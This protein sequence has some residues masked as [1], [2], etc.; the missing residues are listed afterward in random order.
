MADAS[1]AEREPIE[2]LAEEFLQRRRSGQAPT[3][4]EYVE[5]YPELADEIRAVFPTLLLMERADPGTSE[6]D[7]DSVDSDG[8]RPDG[9][10]SQLG[11]FR[12]LR[13]VGRGGMGVVYEAEQVSLGRRVALKVLPAQALGNPRYLSRFER[14]AKAA[15]RLHHTNI[16]PVYGVGTDRGI[17]YY[18]MQF[19]HGQALNEVLGELKRLRKEKCLTPGLPVVAAD[20]GDVSVAEVARSLLTGPAAQPTV[21]QPREPASDSA[22]SRDRA[23][24]SSAGGSSTFTGPTSSTYAQRAYWQSVARVGL[25][26]AEALAY[27]HSEGILHRDIKPSNLLLDARGH[28]W[29]TDFG[30]AKTAD[31]EDLTTTGDIVGTVRYMA[32]ERFQG[33]NDV[34]SDVYALGV[35]LYE[36][37]ALTPAYAETDRHQLIKLVTTEEPTHLRRAAP[38][39]PRDLRTIVHK[40]IDR[41]PARRYAS[42]AA[43]AD[44]LQRFLED[45]PIQARPPGRAELFGRWCRRNPVV[46]SLLAAVLLVTLLGFAGIVIQW[47]EAVASSVLAETNAQLAYKQGEEIQK[48]NH[49]LVEAQGIVE[50]RNQA[51]RSSQDRLRRALYLSDVR[52]LPVAWEQESLGLMVDSLQRQVPRD[53]EPDLR[54]FEWHYWNRMCQPDSEVQ[55]EREKQSNYLRFADLITFSPDGTMVAGLPGSAP[56]LTLWDSR[57]GKIRLAT[58]QTVVAELGKYPVGPHIAFSPDG[59][60]MA[61]SSNARTTIKGRPLQYNLMVWD[62]ATGQEVWHT[63]EQNHVGYRESKYASI[64]K[65][66]PGTY[67]AFDADASRLAACVV[68]GNRTFIK[69]WDAGTGEPL[70]E[71]GSHDTSLGTFEGTIDFSPDGSRLLALV[72]SKGSTG[73]AVTRLAVWDAGS[74]EE[75][76]S[77]ASPAPNANPVS[78]SFSNDGTLAVVW[79]ASA[80]PA[81]GLA[82]TSAVWLHDA[83]T[84]RPRSL[85]AAHQGDGGYISFVKFSVAGK[86]LLTLSNLGAIKIWDTATQHVLRRLPNPLGKVRAIGFD[87]ENKVFTA[88]TDGVLKTWEIANRP[89]VLPLS[90]PS[91]LLPPILSA[92]GK[93]LVVGSRDQSVPEI[94]WPFAV[95]SART[96]GLLGSPLAREPVLAMSAYVAARA[97]KRPP[98][99]I[100]VRDADTGAPMLTVKSERGHYALSANGKRLASWEWDFERTVPN[101]VI[102]WE[103]DTGKRVATIALAD[104]PT[105]VQ[106][107][108]LSADGSRLAVYTDST[109]PRRGS[110]NVWDV[111]TSTVLLHQELEPAVDLAFSPD[112]NRIAFRQMPLGTNKPAFHVRDV[113][114]GK[115]VWT[116][117][118]YGPYAFSADGRRLAI[119]LNYRSEPK[120]T[121]VADAA[122]GEELLRLDAEDDRTSAVALNHDGQRLLTIGRAVRLWDVET[123]AELLTLDRAPDEKTKNQL[124]LTLTGRFQFSDDGRRLFAVRNTVTGLPSQLTEYQ[125]TMQVWDATPLADLRD[126]LAG[127]VQPANNR[128]R[129]RLIAVCKR[130]HRYVAAT[131]FYTDAFIAD[132]SLADDVGAG[133]RYDALCCSL[134]ATAGLGTD[135]DK[136]DDPQ[137]TRLRQQ[138]LAWARSDL[139]MWRKRVDSSLDRY[140]AGIRDPDVDR[141]LALAALKR[142]RTDPDLAGIRDPDAVAKLPEEQRQACEQLWAAVASVI[143]ADAHY[144]R[145]IELEKSQQ[146]TDAIAA[147]RQAIAL[148][149]ASGQFYLRLALA[150]E[151]NKDWNEA[152]AAYRKV[153]GLHPTA[154]NHARLGGALKAGNHLD[155]ARDMFRRAAELDARAVVQMY[156]SQGVTRGNANQL[157]EAI[158]LFRLAIDIDPDYADA[159]ANL[160]WVLQRKGKWNEGMAEGRK[161]IELNPRAGWYHNNLG[162][163]LEHQG[164]LE[165]ALAEYRRA[166]E[167]PSDGG[168]AITNLRNLEPLVARIPRLEAVAKGEARPDDS[169]ECIALAQLAKKMRRWLLAIRLYDE[170]YAA[171]PAVAIARGTTSRY[172]VSCYTV[173]AAI[174]QEDGAETLDD[175]ERA[176]LRKQALAWLR[177]DLNY[178]A[179]RAATGTSG[180]RISVEWE[181]NHWKEDPDLITIRDAAAVAKLPADEREVSRKLWADVEDLLK[182]PWTPQA[183]HPVGPV[184]R[185]E[186]YDL[187]QRKWANLY[188][189]KFAPDGKAFVAGGDTGPRGR[190]RLWE[191]ATGRMLQQFDPGHE[192]WFSG[193]LFLPDGTQFLTWYQ[194]ER[195]LYLWDMA[196]GKLLRKIAGH[197]N[198]PVSVAV[199]PDGKRLLA[200]GN[201]KIIYLYDFATGNE[202]A[203]LAG[204]TD[205]CSAVFS[206]DGKQVLSYSFDQTLRLWDTDSG[207]LLHTLAGHTAPCTGIFSPDGKQVLSYA[208]KVI[209]LWDAA[210][211]NVARVLQGPT[212]EV[213]GAAFLAGGAKVVAWGKDGIVRV[214][215]TGSGKLIHRFD[216]G[217]RAEGSPPQMA[218]T[219][220]GR[221]L[222]FTAARSAV[223]VIDLATGKQLARFDNA[224]QRHGF[225]VSPDS[226]YAGAG[227]FR[228]GV[229]VWRLPK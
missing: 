40:A 59:T 85:F 217:D 25:Q 139:D 102:V 111:A 158:A 199:T 27:A 32:P 67:L 171:N 45:R 107:F 136:L 55:L 15:A 151:A 7:N 39:M 220:D 31:T 156:V 182:K 160:A 22:G 223:I 198:D 108:A 52:L 208:D 4:G 125:V 89:L 190:L 100:E 116:R 19:I 37:A 127:K 129:L 44:D 187:E 73:T 18:A 16:V 159:H 112:G 207:K 105:F 203:R 172:S 229:Y 194:R 179:Q 98:S 61:V 123:G 65:F 141:Y 145:G 204:H 196:S 167:L 165:E 62:A 36:L 63:R 225:S 30:L 177:D 34:R 117:P 49:D 6:L 193:G 153:L 78:F 5:R 47:R 210:T 155:E 162:W 218:V 133:H 164:K 224:V 192:T 216:V 87:G 201:D 88:E 166:L 106:G 142:W 103:I 9:M 84:G 176:A 92:D 119:C 97:I 221:R 54:N 95:A 101:P 60:R 120:E 90:R 53:G 46:V 128:E 163:G 79:H 184:H 202:V 72:E 212:D 219:P 12:I 38:A 157:D 50:Q 82:T 195:D 68:E 41:D 75:L 205:R 48:V 227:S 20:A 94:K 43:L 168:K 131:R 149:P 214:W 71:I 10:P 115:D 215:E 58:K 24:S 77:I 170:A 137:R 213:T 33:Q 175:K 99:I 191:V 124:P 197:V 185:F 69:V 2:I 113:Q 146:W 200:G 144:Q 57:T 83:V 211:G 138:A 96:L 51:L 150:H 74:G 147:Y 3:L 64:P 143:D 126:L 135:A 13:E 178:R 1:S 180:D 228:A 8:K 148:N 81:S 110:L 181:L 35:T 28:V 70:L 154:L 109:M 206:P 183:D 121:L 122:T 29:V 104:R 174:S 21:D 11:D 130:Q 17:H 188:W 23:G 118:W 132:P 14:E 86:S 66:L 189:S 152:I 80:P 76:P 140:P 134:W 91:Y 26:A 209:R 114:T 222:V 161:A 56:N 186:V 173:L 42:A 169:A 93:R 226:R